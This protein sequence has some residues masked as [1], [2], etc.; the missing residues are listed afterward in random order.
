MVSLLQFTIRPNLL[1]KSSPRSG[2]GDISDHEC[3]S[4]RSP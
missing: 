4:K 2:F 3:P 1:S